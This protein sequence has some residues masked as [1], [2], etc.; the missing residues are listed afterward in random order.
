MALFE[1]NRPIQGEFFPI[2]LPLEKYS[3]IGNKNWQDVSMYF[4]LKEERVILTKNGIRPIQG[5]STPVM[6]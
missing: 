2:Y 3:S 4:T 5:E 1:K 6:T